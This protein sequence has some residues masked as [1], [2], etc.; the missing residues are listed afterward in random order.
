MNEYVTKATQAIQYT[1]YHGTFIHSPKLGELEI[2]FNTLIGVNSLGKI[3]FI[4]ENIAEG[5][6]ALELFE[7]EALKTGIKYDRKQINFVDYSKDK[8]KFFLPGFVDTHIHASQYPNIGVGLD[9]QLMDWLKT[10]TFPLENLY[11][12]KNSKDKLSFAKYVYSKVIAK[13]LQNGTTCASYFTTIDPQTTN[14][15]AEL[16]LQLGQRGFVGKVCMD[17]NEQYRE[18]EESL[19]ACKESMGTIISHLNE[20]NPKGEILVKPIVTP[21]F[22]LS[23]SRDMLKY[24]GT[25][26]YEHNLPIQ[27]HISENEKEVELVKAAYPDCDNYALVYEKH[28]LLNRS[29]I[30]AHGVHL[31][32]DERQLIK[33]KNCSISHCPASN[34]FISSGEAPVRRYLYEDKINVSL[35]TD[36]SGGF[37]SSILGVIKYSILVSHHLAIRTKLEKDKLSISDCIFMATQAGANAVGLSDKIGSF[38]L[39][40]AFDVQLIDLEHSGSNIDVF[41][42]QKPLETDSLDL[43][44]KKMYDLL[45]KWIFSGDDRNCS[46][47]WCNGRLVFNKLDQENDK[48]VLINGP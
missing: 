27:T 21:R 24:L 5:A 45:G 35:G 47:V 19:D 8:T 6:S 44:K 38:E 39:G 40:K 17:H 43:K 31:N 11:T 14:L 48:W 28:N 22:A 32:E 3:D 12:D 23:C 1:L 36:V 30:L 16:L 29:T 7:A 10:Y 4:R 37:E 42:W 18:Y 25:L 9:T 26:S 20:I 46:K 13:T 34:T 33:E 2:H 15:F 41:E